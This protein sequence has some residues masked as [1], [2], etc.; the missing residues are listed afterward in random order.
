MKTSVTLPDDLMVV[1]DG[2]VDADQQKIVDAARSRLAMRESYPT[3]PVHITDLIADA[4]REAIVEG[5]VDYKHRPMPGSTSCRYCRAVAGY[6]EYDR[7][8]GNHQK[9]EPNYDKPQYMNG[10]DFTRYM[11]ACQTCAE[12]AKALIVEQLSGKPIQISKSLSGK[13]PDFIKSMVYQCACGWRGPEIHLLTEPGWG[14]GPDL[15]KRCPN[16]S[17]RAELGFGSRLCWVKPIEYIVVPESTRAGRYVKPAPEPKPPP[18]MQLV[19]SNL[20]VSQS[21]ECPPPRLEIA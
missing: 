20:H 5:E 8:R 10:Y 18:L 11:T 15:H 9:G 19:V 13:P 3:L 6:L 17:E 4:C 16:C 2:R 14:G 12:S 1:L 21:A 7:T